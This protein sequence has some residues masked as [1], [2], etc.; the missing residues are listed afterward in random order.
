MG[1]SA[2][3]PNRYTVFMRTLTA[4][5]GLIL[6]TLISL[7]TIGAPVYANNGQGGPNAHTAPGV[8]TSAAARAHV[9]GGWRTPAPTPFTGPGYYHAGAQQVLTGTDYTGGVSS[10]MYIAKPFIPSGQCVSGGDHSLM[11]LAIRDAAGNVVEVGW[12]EEPSAFGDCKPRL[13][14][15][16]WKGNGSGGGTWNGCYD[17]HTTTC[18]FVDNNANP[19]DLGS[20]LTATA[21]LCNGTSL[22][23]VKTFQAYWSATSCGPAAS[24]VFITYDLVSVGCFYSPAFYNNIIPSSFTI[25]QGFGEYYYAGATKPCGDMGN[26]VSAST[27][28]GNTGP[29]YIGPVSLANPSPSTLTASFTAVTPTDSAAYNVGTVL[30]GKTYATSGAGYTSSGGTPGNAGNC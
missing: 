24:G 28:L 1:V 29:A 7:L 26:G 19:I 12:A 10:K 3:K 14:A 11:E 25:L 21:N 9:P 18:Y 23:C 27:A 15:S 30:G 4:R 2:G 22:S 17:G 6:T 20:D 13:F 5:I 16:T 8:N